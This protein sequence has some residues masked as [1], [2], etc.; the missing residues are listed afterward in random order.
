M[1]ALGRLA[2]GRGDRGGPGSAADG[3]RVDRLLVAVGDRVKAGQVVADPRPLPRR[4]AAVVQVAGPGRGRPGQARP[5]EGRPEDRGRPGQEALIEPLPGRVPRGRRGPGAGVAPAEESRPARARIST[6]RPSKYEQARESL[7]QAKAQ[8]DAMKAIRPV[9]VKVAEAEL[10]QAEAG[11]AVAQA[12]LE[13]AEVRS[14]ITGRVLRIHVSARRSAS[15][16]RA[17][18]R[19]AIPT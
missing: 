5:G 7:N 14:P 8:L 12:D 9:D 4:E 13:A 19:S 16:T 11:L 18:S 2:R 15:A 6:T 17:S 1:H 10:I 3:G